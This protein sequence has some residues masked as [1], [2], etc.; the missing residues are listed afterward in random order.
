MKSPND[1][2]ALQEDLEKLYSWQRKNNMVFNG[3]KFE[4]LRYGK[5]ED[6][7][8]STSYLTPEAEDLIE[9][10]ECLRDLGIKMSDDAKFSEH[11]NH[12]SSKVR[13]KCGWILRTFS[14]RKTFLMKFL[15]KTLVQ[16]HIDYCS[17]LYFPN[18][19]KELEMLEDLQ[20]NFSKKIPEIHHLDY[21]SRLKH[22]QLYSQQRRSERYRIIYT[23]KVLEGMVPNCGI[24]HT[25]NDRRGR[26]CL[27]PAIKGRKPVQNLR[28]QSFQVMGPR[29]FNSLP[30]R[31]RS[32]RKT[33]VE[34][35]KEKLDDFLSTL[36][37]H[38]KVGDM[39]PSICNQV[40]ARPS[41]SLTDVIN[42]QKNIYGGG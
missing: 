29:L 26:E 11:I 38:P 2:E 37:D 39:T 27:I 13:Q 17:Q 9:V 22:L 14:C 30:K 32:I 34:E 24:Q 40:T 16:G 4:L 19:S 28:E 7:K 15:W 42:H 10:K 21:W 12:V 6:L 5:D 33:T 3:K 36:P 35:F 23:W 41:N 8:N 20:K 25:F 18:Q 1:V 31:L